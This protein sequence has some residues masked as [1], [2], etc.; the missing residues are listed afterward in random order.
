MSERTYTSA[1]GYR[2][3]YQGSESD[4]EI[5][6]GND[7]YNT[8]YRLLDVR[9]GRWFS[10]DLLKAGTP[11]QSPYNSMDN[12]PILHTDVL[13]LD[14]SYG[15]KGHGNRLRNWINSV[16]SRIFS[17]KARQDFRDRKADHSKV[18]TYNR[19]A[20]GDEAALSDGGDSR[21]SKT[22]KDG[23]EVVYINYSRAV[24]FTGEFRFNTN[25][26]DKVIV[27]L[28]SYNPKVGSTGYDKYH[29]PEFDGAKGSVNLNEH[30]GWQA[31]IRLGNQF[32]GYTTTIWSDRTKVYENSNTGRANFRVN[33]NVSFDITPMQSLYKAYAENGSIS[34]QDAPY[35]VTIILTSPERT[36]SRTRYGP[37]GIFSTQPVL[38]IYDSTQIKRRRPGKKM[39]TSITVHAK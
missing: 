27:G 2:F 28:N 3:G 30:S 31:S 5:H 24:R 20:E 6:N 14:I 26:I 18:Y 25:V 10:A 7:V 33:S 22:K 32:N 13:G 17:K 39:G 4:Q 38:Q 11:W 15:K 34:G 37:F 36:Y 29:K 1:A 9:L 23:K 12:N 8:E 19:N 16:I 21:K 35:G